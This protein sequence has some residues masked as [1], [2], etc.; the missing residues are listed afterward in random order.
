PLPSA[1]PLLSY[2]HASHPPLPSFPTRRSS[3]LKQAFLDHH[4]PAAQVFLSR[5]ENE[6]HPT[7]EIRVGGEFASRSQQHS[8]VSV[9][10]AR[11]HLDRKSTRL[12]SSHVKIS[13]AVFC[14]KKKKKKID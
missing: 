13:Y 3:D 8:G 11:M 5:L 10:S 14:L 12:N 7:S 1:S 4:S 6:V 9:M 2:S